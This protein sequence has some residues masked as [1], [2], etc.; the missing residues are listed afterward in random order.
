[1]KRT[2]VLSAAF[3][4]LLVGAVAFALRLGGSKG[5][6]NV[7]AGSSGAIPPRQTDTTS[8]SGGFAATVPKA[9]SRA[10]RED[11]AVDLVARYGESRTRLARDVS[12]NVVGLLDDV[13]EMGEMM[14]EGRGVDF[15]RGQGELRRVLRGTGVELN[16]DQEQRADEL[17]TG[18]QRRELERTRASVAGLRSDPTALMG[19]LLASDARSREE[20]SEDEYAALQAAN[21][22]ELGDIINPLDHSNFRGRPPLEDEQFRRGFEALLEPEQ[23]SVFAES[24]AEKETGSEESSSRTDITQ[25]PV[26]DLETADEAIHS[27]RLMTSGFK[28]VVEGMGGLGPLLEQQRGSRRGADAE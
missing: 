28:Q 15:G 6:E 19:M 16:E 18:F 13:I 4:A 27:T 12:Q 1:M 8:E 22:H 17:M 26:M 5:D 3:L 2:V 7:E 9:S 24:M 10:D 25:L 14:V 11:P 23:A 21:A 20:L